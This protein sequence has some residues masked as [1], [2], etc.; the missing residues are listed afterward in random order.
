MSRF[1]FIHFVYTFLNF[2]NHIICS[3]KM[4]VVSDVALG[5]KT[6]E[7]FSFRY[8]AFSY[9]KIIQACINLDRV[10]VNLLLSV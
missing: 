3:G 8:F 1:I 5:D 10:C 9:F 4:I 2:V 7:E 6:S